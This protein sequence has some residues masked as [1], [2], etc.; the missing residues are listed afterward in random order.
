MASLVVELEHDEV[1]TPGPVGRYGGIAQER[2]PVT[3]GRIPVPGPQQDKYAL[4]DQDGLQRLVHVHHGR[5]CAVPHPVKVRC[6]PCEGRDSHR[7]VSC[8]A[9]ALKHKYGVAQSGFGGA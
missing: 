5:R 4:L 1:R 7:A 2:E 8:G 9:C 6:S 3:D